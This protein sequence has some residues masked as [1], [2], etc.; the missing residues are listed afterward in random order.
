MVFIFTAIVLFVIQYQRKII[1]K[2]SLLAK[3]DLDFQKRL[4]ESSVDTKENEMR[5]I[6]R[7]LH[8]AIGSE[9]NAL[10]FSIHN[11]EMES[12]IKEKLNTECI[13]I[14]KSIRRISEEL[15]P[16][17]LEKLG[18]RAATE[19]YL[20]QIKKATTIEVNNQYECSD[21]FVLEDRVALSLFRIIQ[22]LVNNILKHNAARSISF[23]YFHNENYLEI[24]IADDGFFFVPKVKSIENHTGHG[25]L[26]IESR[27]Q[28]IQAS[29]SILENKPCGT[30][31]KIRLNKLCSE[32]LESEL[33]R[34]KKYFEEV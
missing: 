11:A 20:D 12:S 15:M 22:E 14:S 7:E 25:L 4:L 1:E 23:H 19:T 28:L 3:K 30:I 18:L 2:S 27:L 32:E 9:I 5:R 34:T 26:N 24:T 33:L 10:R 8:D 16:I 31:V 21:S 17:T 6:S 29:I 13:N